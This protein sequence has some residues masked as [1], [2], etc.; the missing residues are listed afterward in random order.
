MTRVLKA[1]FLHLIAIS[2]VLASGCGSD[3][4]VVDPSEKLCRGNSG[5]A[6]RISGT[7]EPIEMCVSDE[8]T[9]TT[10][11]PGSGSLGP[12]YVS[13]AAFSVDSLQIEI[14]ISFFVHSA[15]PVS[16]EP[17]SNRALA[18]NNPGAVL[19]VYRETKLGDYE[20]EPGTVSGA[21]IL[22]LSDESVAAATFSD[23]N[24]ELDDAANGTA[25][26]TRVISEGYL[27]IS[28]GR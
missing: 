1:F 19:F 14:E 28:L 16:L 2:L 10:Y 21:F 4:D 15:T 18:E 7:P 6:T 23:L 3:S 20:Y 22:T 24:I 5:F 11:L 26:A 12:R 9:L 25:A 27:L 8:Q 13:I 17:T